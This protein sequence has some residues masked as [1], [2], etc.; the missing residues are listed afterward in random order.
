MDPE[1]HKK[2]RRRL[3]MF[4]FAAVMNFVM[5]LWVMSA[6][7]QVASGTRTVIVVI[8]LGFAA[9][10]YYMA[11]KLRAQWEAYLRQQQQGGGDPAQG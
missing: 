5:A 9:L 11:K 1:L 7:G 3:Y 8:F 2:L 6:G 10:N 4:Y